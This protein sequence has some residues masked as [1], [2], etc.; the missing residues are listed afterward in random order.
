MWVN[1]VCETICF[2]NHK[3]KERLPRFARDDRPFVIA[4]SRIMTTKSF[5]IRKGG[6]QSRFITWVWTKRRDRHASLAMTDYQ[7]RMPQFASDNRLTERSPRSHAPSRWQILLHFNPPD[8]E[9]HLSCHCEP[10]G[11]DYDEF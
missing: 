9:D 8:Q 7:A 5:C 4:N 2:L 11:F 3:L 6:W 10:P 1:W